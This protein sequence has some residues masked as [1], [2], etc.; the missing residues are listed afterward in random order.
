[1]MIFLNIGSKFVTL[2]L[3]KSQE[4]YLRYNKQTSSLCVAWMG[5]RD[6]IINTY[7]S[8]CYFSRLTNEHINFA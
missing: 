1:M 8:I 7:I 3:S 2:N 6:I 5:T 4:T